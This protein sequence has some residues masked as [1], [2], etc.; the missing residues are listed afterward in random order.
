VLKSSKVFLFTDKEA[1]FSLATAEA[2]AAGLPV[3]AYHSPLFGQVYKK[4]F[5]T[6]AQ[7]DQKAFSQAVIRLLNN[8]KLRKTL[9]RQA[10]KQA[11]LLSWQKPAK[12]FGNLLKSHFS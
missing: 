11:A 4:G 9:S 7:N 3:V 8:S 2:M 1:G 10:L 12:I 6:V 5:I